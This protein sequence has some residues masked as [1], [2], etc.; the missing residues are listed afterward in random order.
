[1]KIDRLPELRSRAS[2]AI[3]IP[4]ND[5]RSDGDGA[6]QDFQQRRKQRL[7]PQL[8]EEIPLWKALLELHRVQHL[9]WLEHQ[10][11][12]SIC[13]RIHLEICIRQFPNEPTTLD[14]TDKRAKDPVARATCLKRAWAS[15]QRK[16]KNKQD[17]EAKKANEDVN[18][19]RRRKRD[20]RIASQAAKMWLSSRDK[21]VERSQYLLAS[22]ATFK[23][24]TRVA[25]ALDA[26]RAGGRKRS[27]YALMDLDSGVTCWCPP[28]AGIVRGQFHLWAQA[29]AG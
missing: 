27:H 20:L 16:T 13:K 25:V 28:Q 3:R 14:F 7:P 6:C 29:S 21:R 24:A 15:R 1:M 10:L 26:T 9:H 11:C 19:R 22:R 5:S 12:Q 2:R 23:G 8:R 17:D 18:V 4:K